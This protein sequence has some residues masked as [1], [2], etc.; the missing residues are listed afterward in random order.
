MDCCDLGTYVCYLETI[1]VS[2]CVS[3]VLV[4]I[5]VKLPIWHFCYNLFCRI[6]L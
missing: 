5:Y 4:I 1:L 2:V 3:L 6:L